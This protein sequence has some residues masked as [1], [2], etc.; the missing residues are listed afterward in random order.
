ML[1]TL[2]DQLHFVRAVQAVDTAGVEPLR[3]LRDET[4]RAERERADDTLK[5]CE[6]AM[7]KEEV[8]GK[9]HK[10]IRRREDLPVEKD[11]EETEDWRA[12]DLAQRKVGKF[13]VVDKGKRKD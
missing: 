8:V 10:R 1:R 12:V 6:E 11:H 3:A 7:E 4:A 2:S 9:Y 5:A 13:F